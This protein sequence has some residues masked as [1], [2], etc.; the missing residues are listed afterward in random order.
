MSELEWARRTIIL[1]ATHHRIQLCVFVLLVRVPDLSQEILKLLYLQQGSLGLVLVSQGDLYIPAL[2]P[3]VGRQLERVDLASA[4]THNEDGVGRVE[5]DVIQSPT[6]ARND[7]LDTDRLVD[8]IEE[9][10]HMDFAILTNTVTMR[11]LCI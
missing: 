4:I 8:I 5:G 3:E 2:L 7:L 10:V 11:S 1:W 9:V 6:L